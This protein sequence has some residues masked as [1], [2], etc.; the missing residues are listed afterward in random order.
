[1]AVSI[2]EVGKHTPLPKVNPLYAA[3]AAL[4]YTAGKIYIP[5]LRDIRAGQAI[6]QDRPVAGLDGAPPEPGQQ[7]G[8]GGW[9]DLAGGTA[10]N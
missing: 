3:I 5:M 8:Q 2:T 4:V 10:I 9:F 6:V 1:L 7:P